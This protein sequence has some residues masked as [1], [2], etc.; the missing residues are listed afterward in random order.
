M[1]AA[2]L[3]AGTRRRHAGALIALGHAAVEIPLMLVIIG[4]AGALFELKG[5][6]LTVGLAGGAV[7][8]LMGFQLLSAARNAPGDLEASSERHPFLTGILLT[9]AN[10]YF[11][12]WWATGGLALATKAAELGL[13]AFVLFAVIHWLCDLVWLEALSLA[14]H[15]GAKLLRGRTQQIVLVVCG[16][17]LVGFGLMFL[18]DAGKGLFRTELAK[19]HGRTA[20]VSTA[21]NRLAERVAGR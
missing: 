18:F 3:A 17:A 1:T 11:L 4:G 20:T 13:V 5:F 8:L 12:I 19:P 9:G 14:S 6:K 15:E 10:P 21:R 2:T 7:L 16:V